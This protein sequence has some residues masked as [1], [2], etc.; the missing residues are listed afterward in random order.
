ML[1]SVKATQTRRIELRS[2]HGVILDDDDDSVNNG[3]VVEDGMPC[4]SNVGGKFWGILAGQAVV[5]KKS[6]LISKEAQRGRTQIDGGTRD[7][8]SDRGPFL[9]VQAVVTAQRI[10]RLLALRTNRQRFGETEYQIRGV[11]RNRA[12][13]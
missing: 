5:T 4:V 8:G 1:I 10:E 11:Q 3:D 13:G 12:R 9:K 7:G 2:N 6:N